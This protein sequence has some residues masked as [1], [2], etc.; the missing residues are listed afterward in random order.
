MQVAMN[1]V[2]SNRSRRMVLSVILLTIVGC[3]G[4]NVPSVEP[5]ADYT[6][7]RSMTGFYDGYV[8]ANHGKPPANEQAFREYLNGKQEMLQET[9]MTADEL[10]VSP[11]GA[12]PLRWASA[13]RRPW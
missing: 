4:P 9:G 1:F 5:L 6:K 10:F 8:K 7:V 12:T 3:G 13:G 2:G 11:R